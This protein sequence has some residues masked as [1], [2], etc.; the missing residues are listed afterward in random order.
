MHIATRTVMNVSKLSATTVVYT[1]PFHHFK[2]HIT[3]YFLKPFR[4]KKKTFSFQPV[5]QVCNPSTPEAE[6]Q[7]KVVF[8]PHRASNLTSLQ[9]SPLHGMAAYLVT[10]VTWFLHKPLQMGLFSPIYSR[11]E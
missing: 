4:E 1:M 11:G 3:T 9:S 7:D 2:H 5:A 10:T 6:A 8:T